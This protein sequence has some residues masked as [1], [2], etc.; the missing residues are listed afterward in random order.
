MFLKI[1]SKYYF[2]RLYFAATARFLWAIGPQ[3]LYAPKKTRRVL[4]EFLD[5]LDFSFFFP[6]K[7]LVSLPIEAVL[8]CSPP[9][10][11]SISGSFSGQ[12]YGGTLRLSELVCLAYL[13]QVLKPKSVLEIGTFR[14]RT[15]ALF[16]ANGEEQIHIWTMDLPPDRCSHI[17]GEFYA[18]S[19]HSKKITQLYGNTLT[20]NFDTYTKSMDFVWIDACHDYKYVVNDTEIAINCTKPGGWIAWHDY[21]HT[22]NWSG[23][24]RHVRDLAN[25]RRLTNIRH[26]LGTSIAIAQVL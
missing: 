1:E 18:P 8:P 12:Y 20:Y 24:T 26:I 4:N 7:T 22:S 21:R 5:A 9:P 10:N 11:I 19:V 3:L 2:I 16:A 15:T 6:D 13:I 17:V 25:D 14:G 23:V